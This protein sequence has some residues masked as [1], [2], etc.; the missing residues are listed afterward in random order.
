M[1]SKPQRRRTASQQDSPAL[2]ASTQE[3]QTQTQQTPGESSSSRFNFRPEHDLLLLEETI[4]V[5]PFAQPHGK[6]KEAWLAIART[7]NSLESPKFNIDPTR[8]Y[9]RIYETLLPKFQAQ[10]MESLK[11]SGTEEEYTRRDQLL[12][13][14]VD[15]IESHKELKAQAAK[16]KADTG[17]KAVTLEHALRKVAEERR[18]EKSGDIMEDDEPH[19]ASPS[20]DPEHAFKKRRRSPDLLHDFLETR[21]EAHQTELELARQ[22]LDIQKKQLEIMKYQHTDLKAELKAELRAEL[23]H[24]FAELKEDLKAMLRHE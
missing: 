8:A 1:T 13:E 4:K 14:L 9:K 20:P 3:T 12:Q 17:A 23:R 5:K 2:S 10:E 24:E 11:A 15:L 19:S 18:R 6:T 7:L 16:T 22:K 21:K